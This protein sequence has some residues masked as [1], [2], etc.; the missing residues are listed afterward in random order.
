M[1]SIEITYELR[2]HDSAHFHGW[3]VWACSEGMEEEYFSSTS[4]N[5]ARAIMR[6]LGAI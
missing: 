3:I 5:E 6:D 1:M 2:R 4:L